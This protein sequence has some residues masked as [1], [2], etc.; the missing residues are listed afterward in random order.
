MKRIALFI[1]AAVIA[2]GIQLLMAGPAI[3][4][5]AN[6]G[7]I[8]FIISPFV[9]GAGAGWIMAFDSDDAPWLAVAASLVGLGIY[10]ATLIIMRW[11]GLICVFFTAPLGIGSNVLGAMISYRHFSRASLPVPPGPPLILLALLC[12]WDIYVGG[13]EDEVEVTTSALVA[14]SPERLWHELLV[15]G[16][17]SPNQ[18]WIFR[19]GVATPVKCEL[20]G[21]GV[22]AY[23]VCTVSTGEI[24]EV[25]TKWVPG[26][27][28]S[29]NALST[30]PPMKEWNPFGEVSAP[31][32]EGHYRVVSGSFLIED[33][34][35]G[36][37]RL[38][39]KTTFA[40]KIRPFGYWSRICAFGVN[41]AHRHV[42]EELRRQ[43]ESPLH[44][45]GVDAGPTG[46]F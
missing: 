10:L 24:P 12:G 6:Y 42:L 19:T 5:W 17:L 8:V 20:F 36:S 7:W 1:L 16:E 43:S 4:F 29:F 27:E 23:R 13:S 14:A 39:R 38:I 45:V 31:H 46:K 34:G 40:Q 33:L 37:S 15:L 3:G 21:E 30:P 28:L 32:L 25:V 41:R 44:L 18:D 2:A 26:K 22:G 35:A 9:A 11:E